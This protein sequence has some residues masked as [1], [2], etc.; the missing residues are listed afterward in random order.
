MIEAFVYPVSAVMKFWHWLLAD[1]FTVSPDTAWVISIF[2]LVVTVRGF[3]VPFNW[4]IFKSSRMM[5][6]MRPEQARLEEQ[7][8]ESLDVDD[9]EAH[10]KALKKLNK[11]YGYNPV[12]GCI[13]PLVQIPFILGLYRLLLWMSV[14]ENGRTG[15][16]IGLL[17]PDDIAGFLQASFLGVPLPAYVSMSSEQ[18]AAL[19]TTS[20]EVRAVAIPMLISA[21]AFTTFNTFVSQLRSRVHLDWDAHMSIKVYHL[22]WW[23]LFIIP[24]MLGI[25]GMTGLIPIAL[26]MYWFLGN[27]WTLIQTIILWWALSVRYPLEDQH[28]EHIETTRGTVTEPSASRRRR[29]LTALTRPWTLPRVRRENKHEKKTEKL[30]RKEKKAHKKTVAKQKR[31]VQSAKRKAEMQRRREERAAAKSS[32]PAAEPTASDEPDPSP[33]PTEPHPE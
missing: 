16:N 1:I 10:E 23:M 4:S 24:I 11:E 25:V 30:E 32:N 19:G 3:L 7:Y 6:M 21:I 27:L 14:P 15:S 22:M 26:L 20:S 2:L 31:E 18:F 9:I 33:S 29:F 13:P 8:G 17:T 5:L 12:T 28:I